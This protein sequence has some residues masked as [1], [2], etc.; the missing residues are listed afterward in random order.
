MKRWISGL[1]IGLI[2]G[3]AGMAGAQIQLFPATVT[4]AERTS[5][6]DRSCRVRSATSISRNRASATSFRR[7]ASFALTFALLSA[8]LKFGILIPDHSD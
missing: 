2:L 7:L 3:L 5:A 1:L 4:Q 8:L 6:A